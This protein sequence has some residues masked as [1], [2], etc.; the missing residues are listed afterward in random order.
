MGVENM[1]GLQERFDL[2]T[3]HFPPRRHRVLC[4]Q[5]TAC[6]TRLVGAKGRAPLDD[7]RIRIH[8]PYPLNFIIHIA[9]GQIYYNLS[10]GSSRI[11]LSLELEHLD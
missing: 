11:P 1:N 5:A 8:Q 10:D 4:P 6:A 7:S 9:R 3:P 2:V